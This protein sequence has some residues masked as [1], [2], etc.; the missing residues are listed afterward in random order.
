MRTQFSLP[1][2]GY[3][4]LL[5]LRSSSI[6]CVCDRNSVVPVHGRAHQRRQLRNAVYAPTVAALSVSGSSETVVGTGVAC[7]ET[8]VAAP[9]LSPPA[10]ARARQTQGQLPASAGAERDCRLCAC[11][12]ACLR[13]AR[14]MWAQ[15]ACVAGSWPLDGRGRRHRRACSCLRR[16]AGACGAGTPVGIAPPASTM[17]AWHCLR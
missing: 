13:A 7:V 12:C 10:S 6:S 11:A 9:A 15:A 3:S 17:F 14:I 5:F 4:F 16:G 2:P 8:K 1:A